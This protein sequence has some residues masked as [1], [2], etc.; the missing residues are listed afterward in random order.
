[1]LKVEM[2]L[3]ARFDTCCVVVQA[4]SKK[5]AY[6][7]GHTGAEKFELFIFGRIMPGQYFGPSDCPKCQLE[8]ACKEAHRCGVCGRGLFVGDVVRRCNVDLL[9]GT[10]RDRWMVVKP[11]TFK[12]SKFVA[13]CATHT[14][15]VESDFYSLG[16]TMLHLLRK[17]TCQQ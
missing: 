16:A 6:A 10:R 2:P 7:C 5:R 13:V 14:V 12:P 9:R 11:Y 8:N 1:M 3:G 4:R 15:K 17:G